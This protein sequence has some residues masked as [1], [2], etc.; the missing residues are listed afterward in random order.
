[1]V[2]LKEGTF[3]ALGD[4]QEYENSGDHIRAQGK[5]Q[6]KPRRGIWE[7]YDLLATFGNIGSVSVGR[8]WLMFG[9]FSEGLFKVLH[10]FFKVLHACAFFGVLR[11]LFL[12]VS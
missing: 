2:E 12:E 10:A 8:C 9:G 3:L 4:I 5:Y 11:A 6:G 7:G 1:M